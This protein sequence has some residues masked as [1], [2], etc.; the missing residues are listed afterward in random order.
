MIDE[1]RAAYQRYRNDWVRE[2]D[3]LDLMVRDAAVAKSLLP[4]NYWQAEHEARLKMR[5]AAAVL[6]ACT[7]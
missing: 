3:V 7:I 4:N 2:K 1:A 5:A 6:E